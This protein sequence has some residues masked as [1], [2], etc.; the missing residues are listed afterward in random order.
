MLEEVLLQLV[1][2]GYRGGAVSTLHLHDLRADIEARHRDGLF[3]AEFYKER[4]TS[5]DFEPPEILPNA[6]SII[7][8]AL[9]DP[10]TQITFT[11]RREA[12]P[13]IVPPTYLHWCEVD[14]RVAD[15]LADILAPSGYRVAL[16]NLPKKLTAVRSGLAAYG[17]NNVSYVPGMGSFH[18]LVALWS[19]LPAKEDNWH[20]L[21]IMDACQKCQACQR[22]CPTGAIASDRFLLHA[23]RCLTFL[24]EKPAEVPFPE[25]VDPAWHNCLVGCL[26]CQRA[27]PENKK[28]RDWIVGDE[29]FSEEETALLLDGVAQERLPSE[30]VAKLERLDL[31]ELLEIIPRNLSALLGD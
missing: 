1:A 10:Q 9:P 16:A 2:R 8:V 28:V 11:W 27:C 20:D 17:K 7:A 23:E 21:R 12:V 22:A 6:T 25:W 13:A 29:L 3:E 26:H 15:A 24:N 4:L 31:I 19:D 18:R 14:K 30:T 5:F